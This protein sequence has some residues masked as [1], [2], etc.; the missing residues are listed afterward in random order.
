MAPD[1]QGTKEEQKHVERQP[2]LRKGH[3]RAT[4][5]EAPGVPAVIAQMD[6]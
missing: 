5:T 6:F 2:P 1:M 3:R 4:W